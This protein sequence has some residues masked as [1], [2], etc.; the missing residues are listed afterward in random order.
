MLRRRL[1]PGLTLA[2]LAA[3]RLF[4][5]DLPPAPEGFAWKRIDS[6]KAEF[7]VPKGWFFKYEENAD[8]RAFFISQESI[9]KGGEFATGLSVN[10]VKLKKDAAP[11]RAMKVIAEYSQL[12]KVQKLW[13]AENGALKL[14]G[15]RIHVTKDPPAFT[16]QV[17]AI[18]NSQTNTLYVIFFES[19]DASWDEAWK[20]GEVILGDF[21]LDDEI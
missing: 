5:E 2:I 11:E 18:G 14:Y 17:L 8:G 21:R 4:A 9:E 1:V 13:E 20:K 15:A 16:E 3:V 19:P 10:V 7:L 6:I 12:G